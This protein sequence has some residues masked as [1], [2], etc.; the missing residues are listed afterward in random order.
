M[1]RARGS[2]RQQFPGI[3]KGKKKYGPPSP[4]P[5]RTAGLPPLLQGKPV[6]G[7][8]T[9]AKKDAA[10]GIALP[11]PFGKRPIGGSSRT[12][13][14][15]PTTQPNVRPAP[16]P[17]PALQPPA[18]VPKPLPK[19]PASS[20]RG[21]AAGTVRSSEDTPH[22]KAPKTPNPAA[23]KKPVKEPSAK[24]GKKG[25]APKV[26][27]PKV[28]E[29]IT[30]PAETAI[31]SLYDP[32]VR[33]LQGLSEAELARQARTADD[34]ARFNQ[35]LLDS[36]KALDASRG[37][38]SNRL[39]TE[40]RTVSENNQRAID[41]RNAD[42]LARAGNDPELAA[43]MGAA[44]VTQGEEARRRED[45]ARLRAGI[46][47]TENQRLEG[48]RNTAMSTGVAR[49]LQ[50]QA[51]AAAAERRTGLSDQAFDL[52]RGRIKDLLGLRQASSEQAS[53]ES[54]NMAKIRQ[55]QAALDALMQREARSDAT[56]RR[57]QDLNAEIAAARLRL[58]AEVN[59]GRMSADEANR[60]LRAEIATLQSATT[61]AVANT[62]AATKRQKERQEAQ[63]KA[64]NFMSAL[65]SSKKV[66]T[67]AEGG[68]NAVLHAVDRLASRFPAI[69][70]R[71]AA[72]II[73]SYYGEGNRH[74]DP[75][76]LK[77][78]ASK[79]RTA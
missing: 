43:K 36:Q 17:R 33:R 54:I 50:N 72:Q 7:P 65:I 14:P 1:A 69:G 56:T 16:L 40:Q 6:Q 78:I 27:E 51:L 20:G 9:P 47:D 2:S 75:R 79:F 12:S 5:K 58:Q 66:P 68:I 29:P 26:S 76:V 18:P 21:A 38:Q 74:K 44:V 37:E 39:I 55:D 28:S 13:G 3:P 57:G 8:P 22:P 10:P 48:V 77:R 4:S 60:S 61:R 53:N 25:A 49:D 45:D 19:P 35:Y 62:G 52:E 32:A 11:P 64:D 31:A 15:A 46:L 73:A 24:K 41:A 70:Q 71:G 30:D 67:G 23:K 63:R 59:A 34:L 42:L